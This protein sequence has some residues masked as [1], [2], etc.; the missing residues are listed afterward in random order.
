M[1]EQVTPFPLH[2]GLSPSA[3]FFIGM[4]L[5]EV[6]LVLLESLAS[7]P[8]GI[9]ARGGLDRI[10]EGLDMAM[11]VFAVGDSCK[12]SG[13]VASCCD[14]RII[15]ELRDELDIAGRVEADRVSDN[16]LRVEIDGVSCVC[17]SKLRSAG[18][19]MGMG[20]SIGVSG[21][22]SVVC[23]DKDGSMSEFRLE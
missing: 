7:R 8:F 4:K 18:G 9:V 10:D 21:S 15:K 22:C 5:D 23:C 11:E 17:A 12:A 2:T 1:M 20:E 13:R 6:R 3:A 19:S 16:E 14:G